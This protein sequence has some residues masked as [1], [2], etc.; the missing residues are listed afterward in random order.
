[1]LSVII[2]RLTSLLREKQRIIINIPSLSGTDHCHVSPCL[3]PGW[4]WEGWKHRG[5]LLNDPDPIIPSFPANKILSCQK[6]FSELVQIYMVQINLRSA[7]KMC[8]LNLVRVHLPCNL[9]SESG[10]P[11]SL[12]RAGLLS[13]P[14]A[15]VKFQVQAFNCS[16]HN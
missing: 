7:V 9:L 3:Q 15:R 5:I 4:G 14:W 12:R 6:N 2:T 16:A 8:Q 10:H 1:M 11:I 13:P